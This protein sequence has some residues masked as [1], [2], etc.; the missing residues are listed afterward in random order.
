MPMY[1][2]EKSFVLRFSLSKQFADDDEADDDD[3]GWMKEWD[4]RLKPE[5]IQ[6]VFGVL[7]SSETWQAHVRNRGRSPDDE[8]E[9][10]LEK[11]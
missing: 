9:I 4:A 11:L 1:T 2:E 3:Y 6:A 8:V 5:I 10:A 7:R